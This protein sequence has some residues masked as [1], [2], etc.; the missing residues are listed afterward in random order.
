MTG[1]GAAHLPDELRSR[2]EE[3][4]LLYLA[5]TVPWVIGYSGGKD[6]TATLQL[7]WEVLANLPAADRHKP[8]H[9][10]TTDTRVESPLVAAWVRTSVDQLRAAAARQ[11]LPIQAHLLEPPVQDSFWVNLIGRGYPAPRHKFRWCT[12]RL[13]IKPSNQFIRSVIES[14]GEAILVLG[15][16]RAESSR[17]AAN[18]AKHDIRRVRDRLTPNANLPGSL[19]YTPI[20][21]WSNDDV[22]L[23]LLQRPNPWGQSNQELVEL[24]AGASPDNE[25]P[26]VVDTTTPSCGTSRFGCWVCTMVER[27]RSM[28]AMIRNDQDNAWM[29]P[30][31][32]LRN[33][34]DVAE[35]TDRREF[36]RMSGKVQLF[37]GRPIHGPY[38]KSWREHWLRRVLQA[39]RAV[40]ERGPMADITLIDREEILEIRRIWLFEKHE[41][42]DAAR[43]IVLEQTGEDLGPLPSLAHGGLPVDLELLQQATG[44]DPALHDLIGR[45]LGVVQ[46]HA[47]QLRRIGVHDELTELVRHRGH[48]SREEAVGEATMLGATEQ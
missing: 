7:V 19:I 28:E 2:R 30:L 35:D 11:G 34:L 16:R 43:Q 24:Y 14:S 20:E 1:Y 5:D 22:W 45:M 37:H 3:L 33:E 4:R 25:C 21:S 15:T 44:G 26:L 38:L 8:I 48:S 40:R 17:R 32:E 10:I 18:M 41:Y 27:D 6:S 36:R 29:R 9:V 46:S 13:K 12:E 31:L 23:Y 39:Q 47:L 42:D